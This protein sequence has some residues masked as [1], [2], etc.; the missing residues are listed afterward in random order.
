MSELPPKDPEAAAAILTA[1][2]EKD[3][4]DTICKFPTCHEPRQATTGSGRPSAY[5]SN[6]EHNAVNN[7]R[8]RRQLKEIAASGTPEAAPKRD[9][10][11]GVAQV[12]SLRQS[13][14]NSMTQLQGN[15]ERYVS[16]LTEIADPDISVAQIQAAQAQSDTRIAEVQ[17][18]LSMERSLR[19]AAEAARQT[20]L[21]N[22]QAEHEA[23]DLAI[24][25]ME[26]SEA[27][28]LRQIEEAEQQL[29]QF[30]AEK[31]SAIAQVEA[32]AQRQREEIERRAQEAKALA[33]AQ[34]AQAQAQARQA[35][36]RAHD[37]ETNART[38]VETAERLVSEARAT[39]DRER[40]EVDRLREE[41]AATRTHAETDRTEARASLERERTEVD[42]LREE[43]A[44][45]RKRAD[46]LGA[47]NDELRAQ[48]M[49]L[50][51]TTESEKKQ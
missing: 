40:T 45:T 25:Q 24:Q 3:A 22:A 49:Q 27:R 26:E 8:A 9:T 51:L 33:E 35:E 15:L 2:Q 1:L 11:A 31:D 18:S 4:D 43:L 7:H 6:T 30:Q 37:A 16:T 46:Q 44:A 34:T 36:T 12:E 48:L 41:L 13:V 29:A 21:Q 32:S 47:L 14:I 20:A 39:L 38:Q 28:R 17:Q 42:R 5:C 23:A 19:L 50:Q 10:L